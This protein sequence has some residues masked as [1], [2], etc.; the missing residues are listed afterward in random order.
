[1]DQ[2]AVALSGAESQIIER[3]SME[4]A[5]TMKGVGKTIKEFVFSLYS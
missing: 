2:F 5:A 4:S 3:Q 1:M